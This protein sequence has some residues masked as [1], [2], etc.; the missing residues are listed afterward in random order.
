MY[1]KAVAARAPQEKLAR[2]GEKIDF[3]GQRLNTAIDGKIGALRGEYGALVSGL[4]ALSPLAVLGRG[5]GLVI[6]EQGKTV[7]DAEKLDKGQRVSVL[8]RDGCVSAEIVDK[9]LKS[10]RVGR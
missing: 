6:D 10:E 1:E 7:A 5:Y 4:E 2:M 9:E 8:L 3:L